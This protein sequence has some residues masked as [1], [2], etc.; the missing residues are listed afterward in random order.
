MNDYIFHNIDLM[1]YFLNIVNDELIINLYF[2]NKFFIA[3]IDTKICENIHCLKKQLRLTNV[4]G[5]SLFIWYNVSQITNNL[6]FSFCQK[7]HFRKWQ[8][9]YENTIEVFGEILGRDVHF[10]SRGNTFMCVQFKNTLKPP[11]TIMFV[12]RALGDNTYF[13]GLNQAFELCHGFPINGQ[14]RICLNLGNR[15]H[16]GTIDGLKLNMYTLTLTETYNLSVRVNNR[17]E[18]SK[19]LSNIE[20][21]GIVIGA[22][23]ERQ[24]K[25][26]GCIHNFFITRYVIP[27]SMLRMIEM[28]YSTAV[29]E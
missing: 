8:D 16:R 6:H 5:T 7:Q 29:R 25:L 11:F 17:I 12:G 22:S 21:Q 14:L 15:L 1:W 20:L 19:K 13:D 28:F 3:L 4:P 2:V 18:I 26:S 24:F 9:R 27:I 10:V 23:R